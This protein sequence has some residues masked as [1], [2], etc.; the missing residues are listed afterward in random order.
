M[1]LI[2]SAT[3]ISGRYLTIGGVKNRDIFP[4]AF[5]NERSKMHNAIAITSNGT[6]GMRGDQCAEIE[7]EVGFL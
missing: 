7:F 2:S 5:Q 4:V 3:R 1:C 6:P